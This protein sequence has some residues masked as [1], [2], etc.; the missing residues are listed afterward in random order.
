MNNDAIVVE[1]L[2]KEYPLY[3]HGYEKYLDFFLPGA[4][5]NRFAALKDVSFV[6]KK[7]QSIGLLGMNGSGKSTLANIIAGISAPTGGSVVVNGEVGMTSVSGGL[8]VLLTGEENIVQKCL[9]LGMTNKEIRELMPQIVEFSELGGF[10]KQQAKTYSSGMRSKLAFAISVNIDP[11]IIV[12]DEALSVGDPTFTDKCLKKMQEF[13]DKGTTII[14]VSHA[15][16][17]VRDFCDHALWLEGGRVRQFGEVNEV[18]DA[19][20]AFI[21][22]FNGLPKT[23]QK[24]IKDEIH[25][26]RMFKRNQ[27]K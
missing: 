1:N 5:S 3:Q 23:E 20:Q 24:K 13:R 10:I 12:I 17:Q 18:C 4:H 8:N 21:T 27:R 6:A 25:K 11:D 16:P 7:G 9:L 26:S 14:F 15:L 19:Y 22:N 2:T